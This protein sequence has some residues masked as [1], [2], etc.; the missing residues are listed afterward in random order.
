MTIASAASPQEAFQFASIVGNASSRTRWSMSIEM[1]LRNATPR[2][3]LNVRR[4][5]CGGWATFLNQCR[6]ELAYH[7]F[8]E[9]QSA[10]HLAASGESRVTRD[11][12]FHRKSPVDDELALRPDAVRWMAELPGHVRPVELGRRFPRIIN[13]LAAKWFDAI[14]CQRYLNSLQFDDRGGREGFSFEIVQEI[15]MLRQHFDAIYP[16]DHDIWKKAFDAGRR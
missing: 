13:T 9:L 12:A 11:L 15:D 6:P 10:V 1:R 16:S 14:G 8:S 3:G 7:D 5:A 2:L 4:L